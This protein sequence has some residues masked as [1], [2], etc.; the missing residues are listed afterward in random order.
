MK[1]R[2]KEFENKIIDYLEETLP[3][4]ETDRVNEHLERCD[5]CSR[6]YDEIRRTYRML[7][8][9]KAPQMQPGFYER[10]KTKMDSERPEAG[11]SI[12]LN[13]FYAAAASILVLIGL[14]L[15][16]LLGSNLA[17]NG[18]SMAS[19]EHTY[20]MDSIASDFYLNT[21]QTASLENFLVEE[22]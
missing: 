7:D 11:K 10:V 6:L 5:Q 18:S 15:G 22:E 4:K 12:R 1:M 14:A 8:Q 21:E 19:E 9:E 20:Y 16:I 17:G 13:R 3:A 2:C